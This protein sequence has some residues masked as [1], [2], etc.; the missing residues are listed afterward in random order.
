[1]N[2]WKTRTR[3]SSRQRGKHF[4]LKPKVGKI[5][6]RLPKVTA[7]RQRHRRLCGFDKQGDIWINPRVKGEDRTRVIEHMKT[8]KELRKQ[9][10]SFTHAYRNALKAEHKGLSKK[11]VQE[12]EGNMGHIARFHPSHRKSYPIV[13]KGFY[14][15][16]YARLKERLKHEPRK[17]STKYLKA[18]IAM[19]SMAYKLT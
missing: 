14:A 3:G 13:P 12:Y 7:K 1:M 15:E 11:Q 5:K 9:G 8:F 6:S 19:Q 18:S 10:Y 4:K 2:S 17:Y 16:S